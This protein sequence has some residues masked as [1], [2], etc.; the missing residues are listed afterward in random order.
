MIQQHTAKKKSEAPFP[1]PLVSQKTGP[2]DL[3]LR[4]FC[5][6]QKHGYWTWYWLRGKRKKG[7]IKRAKIKQNTKSQVGAMEK[8]KGLWNRTGAEWS[9]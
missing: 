6:Y 3:I 5:G 9:E 1:A 7:K 8:E 4:V 2:N